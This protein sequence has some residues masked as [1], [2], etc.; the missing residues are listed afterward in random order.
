[1]P[2]HQV[3]G[4][5]KITTE[6]DTLDF[7]KIFECHQTVMLV[8]EPA[9]G[10]IVHANRSATEFYGW[11]ISALLKKNIAEI[12]ML[13]PEEIQ[14]EMSR[15]LMQQK[16]HFNF[17]HRLAD[18]RIRQVEVRSTPVDWQG[19]SCL[20][21][22]VNDVTEQRWAESQTKL[23]EIKWRTLFESM[24]EMIVLHE[25][26]FDEQGL[27][28][29]YRISD[30]NQ[31]F[32]QTTRFS[33][34]FVVGKPA[35]VLYQSKPA[36]FLDL[37]A[38]VATSGISEQFE[39]YYEPLNLHLSVSVISQEKNKFATIC[40]DITRQKRYEKELQES[41]ALYKSFLQ[42]VPSGI[43]MVIHRVIAKT[44]ARLCAITGYR[45]D[46]LLGQSSRLL[47]PT[48]EEYDCVG[49]E[50]YRQIIENGTGAVET[51]WRRK[52]GTVI[53][54]YLSSTPIDVADWGKGVT[55]T[56]LDI[57]QRKRAEALLL[58]SENRYHAVIEQAP[59]AILLCD[60]LTYDV[61]EANS[62][63]SKQFG[64]ELDRDGPLN[65]FDIIDDQRDQ[66]EAYLAEMR[67]TGYLPPQRRRMYHK[68]G[69][70][71]NVER[72][73]TLAQYRGRSIAV[74]TL[75]NISEEVRQEQAIRKDAEL[76]KR[77]Q[78]AMLPSVTSSKH[79]ELTTVYEAH[80][81][82]GG[83]LFF[84][85]WRYGGNLLR[86][87]LVDAAGHGLATA[88]HTSA[89]HVLLREVNE[90][91]L[92]LHEAMRWLNVRAV[93]YFDE[94]TFAGAIGFELDLQTKQLHWCCAGMPKIW[95]S[96]QRQRGIVSCPGLY[97]GISPE[98]FFETH[99][100]PLSVGDSFCFLTDGLTDLIDDDEPIKNA[101]FSEM[102]EML[103]GL[104]Q[105]PACRDDATAI[106]IRIKSLPE[107]TGRLK[108]WPRILRFEGYGDYRRLKDEVATILA[109]VTGKPHSMQEVAVN[110]ALAN[111]LECRDGIPRQHKARLKI[112]RIG[113]RLVIR[114]K[115]SRIGFAGN[116]L[117][118]RLK[119]RPDEFFDFGED[120]SMGRG[121]PIMLATTNYMTYNNDGTELCLVWIIESYF[122]CQ[123]LC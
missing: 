93:Q 32:C 56:A 9:S 100:L 62:Q 37:Y 81:Y 57:T 98:E 66:I 23:S 55:F 47:Y 45:E 77:I 80:D 123:C 43:G 39:T 63:F 119:S 104:A 58:E 53:D 10:R 83:D 74:L 70:L 103:Q 115:T 116:A 21:S 94:S 34:E 7:R 12:N 78:L 25:L 60:P 75:R 106:C 29:D 84:M 117:L 35:S 72:S 121:I 28:V 17:L 122:C 19:L 110:E 14:L 112:N 49:K 15:A 31:V 4:H 59:E 8:I 64:Y 85:D 113:K 30:C 33:K 40:T 114:V 51:K 91:D 107:P 48:D 120:A 38:K 13:P 46:E 105:S 42:A 26:V 79:I 96:T 6:A 2:N 5:E 71:I 41:E 97:L 73:S 99:A 67:T 3:P 86:G 88:L 61:L 24:A 1:M 109:E 111:A 20:C 87:F 65:L 11:D 27:P 92:P 18:G 101:G 76:A 22:M 82:V 89:M 44:S 95:L 16:K 54:V 69:Y 108:G 50:K 90:M 118:R 102:V 52:D 68:N 36:P